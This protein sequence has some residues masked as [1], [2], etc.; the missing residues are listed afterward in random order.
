MND[1]TG[2]AMMQSSSTSLTISIFGFLVFM[3][4]EGG[5]M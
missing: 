5:Q 4:I 1:D 2:Y 3:Y